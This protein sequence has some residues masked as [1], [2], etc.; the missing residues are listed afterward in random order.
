MDIYITDLKQVCTML[1]HALVGIVYL[2]LCVATD[3]QAFQYLFV[4]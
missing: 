2:Y 3:L 4:L 1:E